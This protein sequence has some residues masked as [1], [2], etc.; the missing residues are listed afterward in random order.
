METPVFLTLE[1]ILDLHQES[2]DRY[3]GSAELRDA[4]LLESAIAM[5]AASFGGDYLHSTL[6][7][8]AAALLFHLVQNHPF[9]DGNKRTGA[10]AARVFLLMNE[11]AFDPTEKDYEALVLGVASGE[12]GKDQ[13]AHFFRKNVKA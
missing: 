9:V 1:E 12:L 8:M 4:G 6:A 5:P 7:E 2:I 11:V 3:G 10:A 13:V